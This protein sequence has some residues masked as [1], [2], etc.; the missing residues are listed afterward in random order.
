MYSRNNLTLFQISL[1]HCFYLEVYKTNLISW[2]VLHSVGFYQRCSKEQTGGFF[3]VTRHVT[4]IVEPLKLERSW[5]RILF[6]FKKYYSKRSCDFIRCNIQLQFS[7]G[8][9][10]HIK[11]Y[12]FLKI[13]QNFSKIFICKDFRIKVGVSH[14]K[15]VILL[16]FYL[17][18]FWNLYFIPI[19]S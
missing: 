11:V 13:Y 4:L 9:R 17:L 5:M 19:L 2:S 18:L 14:M 15:L 10:N 3:H 8:L 12:F 16:P 1:Y 6:R 7:T